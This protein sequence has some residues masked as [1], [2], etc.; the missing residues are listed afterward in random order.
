MTFDSSE[1]ALLT[2]FI[3]GPYILPEIVSL[4]HRPTSTVYCLSFLKTSPHLSSIMLSYF[5][6]SWFFPEV[7]NNKGVSINN[8]KLYFLLPIANWLLCILLLI[9]LR[10]LWSGDLLFP[11]TLENMELKN[12]CYVPTVMK[13]VSGGANILMQVCNPK[14]I[15][16]NS[17]T[18]S[19]QSLIIIF[20]K[21]YVGLFTL[22]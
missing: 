22:I 15:A 6:F 17:A 10:V 2:S 8:N 18:S 20:P 11:V 13:L 12:H 7:D 5:Y 9:F 19:E 3:P 1:T 21:F 16:V 14:T 4:D